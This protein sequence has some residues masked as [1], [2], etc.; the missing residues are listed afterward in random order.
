MCNN[1]HHA[2]GAD[3]IEVV[4]WELLTTDVEGVEG[5]GAVFEEVLF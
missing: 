2:T 3:G 1:L 4:L 5:I